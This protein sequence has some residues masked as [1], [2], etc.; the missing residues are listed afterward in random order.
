MPVKPLVVKGDPKNLG[1]TVIL[2]RWPT[3][4]EKTEEFRRKVKDAR[5]GG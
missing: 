4:E 3:A 1:K 2:S 5:R